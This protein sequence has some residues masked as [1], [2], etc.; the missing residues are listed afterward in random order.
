MVK[1]SLDKEFYDLVTQHYLFHRIIESSARIAGGFYDEM[2]EADDEEE[3]E[4]TNDENKGNGDENNDR[5]SSTD[6]DNESNHFLYTYKWG[7]GV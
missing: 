3:D 6:D 2:L 5:E 7:P 4:G 1:W